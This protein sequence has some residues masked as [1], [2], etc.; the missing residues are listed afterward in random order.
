M[1][2]TFSD[3]FFESLKTLARHQT[4]WYRTYYFFRKSLP[5]FF[6]NIYLFRR[7]LFEHEWWDYSFTLNMLERSL[8]I[9]TKGME[10]K[11]ME[12]S[13]TRYPKVMAMKKAL[14]ILENIKAGNSIERAEKELG[15]LKNMDKPIFSNFEESEEDK[16]HNGKV[17]RRA[18]EI[19]DQEWKELWN[20]FK[21]TDNS[22]RTDDKY[23]GTDMRGWWD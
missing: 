22:K 5:R 2:V 7:E 15:G 11:G 1:K 12:I 20:I 9:M 17:F 18:Q 16:A 6:K 3:S 10:T 19:E 8:R 4:W 13:E 23:D 21:G 14:G